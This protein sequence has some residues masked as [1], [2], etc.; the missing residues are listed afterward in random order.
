MSENAFIWDEEAAGEFPM[1]TTAYRPLPNDSILRIAREKMNC[2]T[3]GQ[4]LAFLACIVGMSILAAVFSKKSTAFDVKL[5]WKVGDGPFDR[6][7]LDL[8]F[9][10]YMDEALVRNET[11]SHSHNWDERSVESPSKL[12]SHFFHQIPTCNKLIIKAQA[13]EGLTYDRLVFKKFVIEVEQVGT[14]VNFGENDCSKICWG[15]WSSQKSFCNCK[16]ERVVAL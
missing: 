1:P 10:F 7:P 15:N 5:E 4:L 11:I 12:H 16:M 9:L 14:L 3:K 2:R 13:E 6:S 8:N